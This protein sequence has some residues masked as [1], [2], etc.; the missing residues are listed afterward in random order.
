MCIILLL[1]VCRAPITSR[2]LLLRGPNHYIVYCILYFHCKLFLYWLNKWNEKKQKKSGV[3][4]TPHRISNPRYFCSSAM[5]LSIAPHRLVDNL[6]CTQR[7]T[8]ISLC[9]HIYFIKLRCWLV[10]TKYT[11]HLWS[12]RKWPWALA[13]V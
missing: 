2:F 12:Q 3:Q 7:A 6:G 5:L 10:F 4:K 11:V 8:S 1:F 9:L 13:Q